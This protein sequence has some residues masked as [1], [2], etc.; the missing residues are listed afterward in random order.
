MTL[1]FI[2]LDLTLVFLTLKNILYAKIAI[3]VNVFLC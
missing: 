3:A 1:F 2:Y